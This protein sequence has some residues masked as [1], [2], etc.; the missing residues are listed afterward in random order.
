M[1]ELAALPASFF[2]ALYLRA[3]QLGGLGLLA[4]GLGGLLAE[5]ASWLFG[6]D[7]IAGDQRLRTFSPER[8]AY[9]TEPRFHQPNCASG[10][11]YHSFGDTVEYGLVIAIAGGLVFAFHTW[12][13]R[14]VGAGEYDGFTR[15]A[16]LAIGSVVFLAGAA[17]FLPTGV[18]SV[19]VDPRLGGGR[20]LL[21][22]LVAAAFAAGYARSLAREL[23]LVTR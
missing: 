1:R 14:R 2:L 16:Y 11:V 8:C 18:A 10:A 3:A 15:R 5:P 22:G 19:L 6:M 7:F 21:V 4:L 23:T 12:W 9:L 20:A 13:L 17:L